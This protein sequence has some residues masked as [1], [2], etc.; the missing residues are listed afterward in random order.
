MVKC[1]GALVSLAAALPA[2]CQPAAFD[3]ASIKPSQIG[4]DS[5][6]W[7]SRL[8]YIVMKN[9]TLQRLVAIA[10]GF[11][12]EQRVLGGPKWGGSDRFDVEA[13]A[14]GPAKDPELLLMLQTLLAQRFQ[15]VVHR[16][17]KNGSGFSLAL[18]KSGLKI[19]PDET[20][21]KQVWN[22]RR[23]KIVAERVSMAKVAESLTG[24]LGAPVVD[25]TDAKGRYSFT[26]EW[27]PDAPHTPGPDGT[28]AAAP[29]G[30][31]LEDVLASQLGVKLENRKLAIEVIVID[32]AEKP[33]EN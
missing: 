4:T 3:A 12:D 6:S 16:E 17:T 30:P 1:I 18:I 33:T 26:L 7:N 9:Q 11:T 20:E 19:H 8:G 32:R 10:Y 25:M 14:V 21:G 28:S 29:S 22:S 27:T 5:S 15:L 31:S 23:G 13:R 24:L 2:F